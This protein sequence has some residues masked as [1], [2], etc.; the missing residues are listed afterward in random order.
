MESLRILRSIT[1]VTLAVWPMYADVCPTRYF[2]TGI[3]PAATND[4]RM[5]EAHVEI[6]WGTPCDL[7]AQFVLEN[8]T[9]NACAAVVGFPIQSRRKSESTN[10]SKFAIAFDGIDNADARFVERPTALTNWWKWPAWFQCPHTFKPGKTSVTITS[11]LPASDDLLVAHT[12]NL[13]YSIETGG[14]WR[15]PIGHEDVT[16]RFPET[17][18]N[19]QILAV[20]PS[21]GVVSGNTIRWEF[22]ELKPTNAA[23]D[24]HVRYLRPDVSTA[25]AELRAKHATEPGNTNATL[26]LALCL[27]GLGPLEGCRGLPPSR[28]SKAEYEVIWRKMKDL[29]AEAFLESQYE[30]AKDGWYTREKKQM[31]MQQCEA[32]IA[33][34]SQPSRGDSN[35]VTEASALFVKLALEG[36]RLGELLSEV[37]YQPPYGKSRHVDEA[38]SLVEEVLHDNP[39][40]A[41]AWNIYLANY[42]RFNF[43]GTAP[44]IVGLDVPIV[45]QVRCIREAATNCPGDRM[46][47]LWSRLCHRPED[48]DAY[49]RAGEE[50]LE[51]LRKTGILDAGFRKIDYECW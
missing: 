5:V 1:L 12:E 50:L 9:T 3:V 24:I 40:N 13:Y 36:S 2:G 34:Q 22:S 29:H 33:A 27:F 26:R 18:S 39:H 48:R 42:Y 32:S 17:T 30:L 38:R 6:R 51:R 49:G 31:M 19:L 4:I 16:I 14:Y 44:F 46:I 21:N 28:L 47:E 8:V 11:V 23:H 35:R 45:R 43:G 7:S 41:E 25:L 10:A 20:S 37:D 15:G